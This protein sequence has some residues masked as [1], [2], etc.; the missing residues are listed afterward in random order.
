M[1]NKCRK[2]SP[3]SLISEQELKNISEQIEK[4]DTVFGRYLEKQEFS[5]IG[6]EN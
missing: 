5:Y 1:A 2:K 6:Y 3:I 4:S